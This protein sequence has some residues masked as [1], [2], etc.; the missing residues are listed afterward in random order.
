LGIRSGWIGGYGGSTSE[1]PDDGLYNHSADQSNVEILL[2]R[3]PSLRTLYLRFDRVPVGFPADLSSLEQLRNLTLDCG[4]DLEDLEECEH[5]MRLASLGALFRLRR[6]NLSTERVLELPTHLF[7]LSQL[8][9]L[10]LQLEEL[11]S[12]PRQIS[13]LPQLSTFHL[14]SRDIRALPGTFSQL[15]SLQHL[16]LFCPS[17]QELPPGLE[18]L[19]DLRTLD[20]PSSELR[21]LPDQLGNLQQ[22]ATLCLTSDK[23]TEVLS[24]TVSELHS[25]QHLKLRCARLRALPQGM[26]LLTRLETLDITTGEDLQGPPLS[27]ANMSRLTALVVSGHLV[28]PS[29]P[30]LTIHPRLPEGATELPGLQSLQLYCFLTG[31]VLP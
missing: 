2:S 30:E 7:R 24:P 23:V 4:K 21:S 10:R 15:H 31:H 19:T 16:K 13:C 9:D 17:L 25:L 14:R 5:D 28:N 1:G 22:L 6:L 12:L 26:E 18:L 20:I 29:F 8:Q 3:C 11:E 27:L